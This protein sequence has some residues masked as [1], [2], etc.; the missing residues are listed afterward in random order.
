M[1][2]T[3]ICRYKDTLLQQKLEHSKYD[4]LPDAF[5]DTYNA[6]TLVGCEMVNTMMKNMESHENLPLVQISLVFEFFFLQNELKQYFSL[7]MYYA[8]YHLYSLNCS[9]YLLSF[10]CMCLFN[11]Q[12]K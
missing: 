1:K 6:I 11:Q 12:T 9:T 2:A 5:I 7:S 8:F 3:L 4:Y 10:F